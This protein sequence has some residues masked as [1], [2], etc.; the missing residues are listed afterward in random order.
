[1]LFFSTFLLSFSSLS[2]LFASSFTFASASRCC[3]F[4]SVAC[5]AAS[6]RSPAILAASAFSAALAA[7]L[8]SFLDFF[9]LSA[10]PSAR[11]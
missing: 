5:L 4:F 8:I 9:G 10:G 3:C 2:F 7:F 1:L 11:T 6:A